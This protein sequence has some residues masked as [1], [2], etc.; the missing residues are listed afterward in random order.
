M[1]TLTQ[2]IR[3]WADVHLLR[4]LTDSQLVERFLGKQEEDA[5]AELVRRH[6]PMV[7]SVCRRVLRHEHDAEDAFQATFLVLARKAASIRQQGSIG[8]WLFQVAQRLAL[9]ARALGER[10]RAC[11]TAA[12]VADFPGKQ[13]GVA[14]FLHEELAHLPDQYRT[15]MVLCYLEGRTQAEAA[16]LLATTADAINS[17]LKRARDLLR[18][19]LVRIGAGLSVTTLAEVLADGAAQAA[20]PA[21]LVRATAQAAINF[22]TRRG[23]ACGA[24]VL[25][26]ALANGALRSMMITKLKLLSVASVL[27]ALLTTGSLLVFALEDDPETRAAGSRVHRPIPA[28]KG[29]PAAAGKAKPIRS[30]ILLW[31][32]GGPSQIDT[33]DPKP[34][35]VNGGPF[36]AIDTAIKG[37]QFSQHLPILAQQAKHLAVIRSMSHREGDHNRS[38]S[39]MR[40]GRTFDG[41]AYPALGCVLAKELGKDRP[42]LPPYIRIA[43]PPAGLMP[44]GVGPGYLGPRYAPLAVGGRRQFQGPEAAGDLLRL[45][46]IEA[47]E[48]ITKK[49]PDKMRTAIAKA[50]E[51]DK[52]KPE[53]R[54]AYGP[55]L[56]GQG[57]LLARRLVELG[58][59]VVEVTL[60]GWDTHANNFALVSKLSARLD[61]GWG[62]LLKEL[63]DRKRLDS[64]LIVWMGEFGRTP[65]INPQNGRDH[66]MNGFTAVLAGCGI[67]GGKVIGKTSADGIRIEERPVSP[68]ELHATIYQALGIDPTKQYESNT[69]QQI[70]LVNAGARPVKEALR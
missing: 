39:L 34:G 14:A 26:A 11:M 38:T 13:G 54:A 57:C 17:R 29:K 59:P 42:D 19:R 68:A 41:T 51:L 49:D 9:R 30:C 6:G 31:M 56:F 55:G 20:L 7:L 35:H 61:S 16:R 36:F 24:S 60:P 70:P 53:V 3:R 48:A 15:V 67:K 4:D 44:V 2:H 32:G 1:T 63:S 18:E 58:V 40:T 33:F 28:A 22:V 45:P 5:F 10:R 47:F 52:E 12:N 37:V 66:W 64:T 23:V 43:S 46:P 25:P 50:F 65:R 27:M 69:G 62:T 21:S 8:G